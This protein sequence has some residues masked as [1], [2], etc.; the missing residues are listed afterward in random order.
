MK[1]FAAFGEIMLRLS[2]PGRERL[3]QSPR[4]EVG[5]GGAEANVAVSLARFGHR[6]RYVSVVPANPAG[7]AVVGELRRYGVETDCV[8]RQGRRLGTYFAEP[9]ANQRP[10]RVV[11]DR[12]HSAIAEARVGDI[13]WA[14]ALAGMD[15][16]H[17]TGITP[18][19]S[20]GAADLALEGARRAQAAGL[21]V[22]LDL[23]YRSKLWTYG[24]PAPEVMGELARFADL[25]VANEE[26]IQRSLGLTA[27]TGDKAGGGPVDIK[28]YEGLAAA[29]MTRFPNVG[30][31]AVT[32]RESLGA[33]HNRWSAVMGT[34]SRFLASRKYDI[35]DVVDRIGTGDAFSA[36]LLH[37]LDVFGSDGEALEFATAASCLKHSIPGDFN[38]ASEK[39]VLDLLAGESTGRI[40]R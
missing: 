13:D 4:L 8:L 23:N 32:L 33:D 26:D 39:E 15:G 16:L 19:L 37:G 11:Y 9:G 36:G 18:A 12:E 31:V 7:D 2:A 6:V 21:S 27:G 28:V 25:I 30:R 40:Q 22:S 17:L 20:P 14:R 34:S 29:V 3:F 38:L 1:S 35:A 24:R 10:S 5:F